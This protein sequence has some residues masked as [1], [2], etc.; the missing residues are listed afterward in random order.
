M[1]VK[2]CFSSRPEQELLDRFLNA[3][4]FY[5][6]EQTESDIRKV[7]STVFNS[8]IRMQRLLGSSNQQGVNAAMALQN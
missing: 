3:P 1:I 4:G 5:V 6:H 7:I 2:I 8:N